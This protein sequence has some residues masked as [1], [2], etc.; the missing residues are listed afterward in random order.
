LH[1]LSVINQYKVDF[2]KLHQFQKPVFIITGTQTV[3][4]HK[5]IDEL[6]TAEFPKGK[7]T[8]FTGGHTAV[9]T[10]STEIVDLLKAF[11]SNKK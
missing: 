9:N 7:T 2:E 6:L 5:K 8:S 1:G 3:P 11:L 10:N 4:F